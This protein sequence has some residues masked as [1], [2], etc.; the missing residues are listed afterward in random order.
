[1][2]HRLKTPSLLFVANLA[3]VTVG[4]DKPADSVATTPRTAEPAVMNDTV[5]A[6]NDV[7]D[8]TADQ[9]HTAVCQLEPIGASE[10]AGT[11]KFVQVG[12]KVTLTGKITGLTPGEHGFH[13]H[14]KGDLSDK[15]TGKSAGG[16][17]NPAGHK[18]G[19]PSD[20]ERHAGDLGNITADDKGVAQLD[21]HDEVISLHGDDS[22]VGKSIV[23]HEGVDQFTQPTGDA[24]GRVAFGLIEVEK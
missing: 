1:M 9:T 21:I 2:F 4:C 23:V 14:E 24:G 19:K 5:P 15:A 7:V 12:D 11:L 22:I 3:F 13:V 6:T 10:V 20:A 16:H 17:F 8:A 18:H